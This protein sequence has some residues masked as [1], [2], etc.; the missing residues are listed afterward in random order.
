[1][2]QPKL[3]QGFALNSK[4]KID[5]ES[6]DDKSILSQYW[7]EYKQITSG[8]ERRKRLEQSL[9]DKPRQDRR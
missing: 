3:C 9:S 6:I 2:I 8:D 5:V 7:L 1:M 4:A